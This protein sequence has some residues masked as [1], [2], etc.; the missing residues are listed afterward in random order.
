M[1]DRKAI[2]LV[3]FVVVLA[4]IAIVETRSRMAGPS[5]DVLNVPPSIEEGLVAD[6]DIISAG[7]NPDGIPALDA[8]SFD[9]VA[10]ADHYLSDDGKGISVTIDGET[11][12]YA[13]RILVWH[14]VVNDTLAGVP[15]MVTY[16]PLSG[17]ALVYDRRMNDQTLT[18]GVSGQ[19]WNSNL[20]LFDRETN[21]LW[22]QLR[23]IAIRGEQT[24]AELIRLPSQITDWKA[25]KTRYP[26]GVALS[27]DT[28][29]VRDYTRN[30]YLGYDENAT[31]MFP[32]S[33]RDDR[34]H[35]KEL[36]YGY[37]GPEG[38]TKAYPQEYLLEFG[39]VTDEVNGR[40]VTFKQ[41]K[42]GDVTLLG[43]SLSGE[44]VEM[45]PV[46]VYWFAWVASYPETDLYDP[47]AEQKN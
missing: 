4:V 10:T 26:Y 22:S 13:Y 3:L 19:L 31:V 32:V 23:G 28:G 30:P 38:E 12:F 8:P 29:F 47:L 15:I 45:L 40:K 1:K 37:V 21:S 18:F 34:L 9:F 24:E 39:N 6:A 33:K 25:W 36:V 44:S 2:F 42:N 16:D 17:S 14:E 35:P 41:E 43:E 46:S 11:R 20:L 5:V 27:R 7:V